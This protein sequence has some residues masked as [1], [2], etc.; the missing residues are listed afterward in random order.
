MAT[1]K[2]QSLRKNICWSP[3]KRNLHVDALPVAPLIIQ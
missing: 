1:I 3:L 2:I